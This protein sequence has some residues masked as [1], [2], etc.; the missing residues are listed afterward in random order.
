MANAERNVPKVIEAEEF[1]I[2][3]RQGNVRGSLGLRADDVMLVLRDRQQKPRVEV[4]IREHDPDSGSDN[5]SYFVLRDAQGNV[6]LSIAMADAEDGAPVLRLNDSR[7]RRRLM[8][9]T[10][11]HGE[12]AQITFTD[13]Q[14]TEIAELFIT[15]HGRPRIHLNDLAGHA[16]VRLG[17]SENGYPSLQFANIDYHTLLDIG[18]TEEGR[19][20]L[21]LRDRD[22]KVRASLVVMSDGEPILRFWDSYEEVT[23]HFP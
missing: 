15:D 22:G 14:T 9:T 8:L 11:Q 7:G 12:N 17:I 10:D 23:H 21:A 4:A 5:L 13:D 1:R 18:I 20:L 19:P 16:R 2:V 3:D 6:R